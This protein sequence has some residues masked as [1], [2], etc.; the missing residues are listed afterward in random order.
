MNLSGCS[1]CF[2]SLVIFSVGEGY[3]NYCPYSCYAY[4]LCL[5]K[6]TVFGK[7]LC[8]CMYFVIVYH[9]LNLYKESEPLCTSKHGILTKSMFSILR[10]QIK[11]QLGWLSVAEVGLHFSYCSI[12]LPHLGLIFSDYF[13]LLLGSSCCFLLLIILWIHI[14]Y[15]VIVN[16]L[17]VKII[18]CNIYLILALFCKEIVGS[19][20]QDLKGRR[21]RKC[22][23]GMLFKIFLH[24]WN[25][26]MLQLKFKHKYIFFPI[27][28]L[29]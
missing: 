12:V 21:C 24:Y 8:W 10:N 25:I 26:I 4:N 14:S 19:C 6:R 3:W 2:I 15:N 29:T 9:L 28:T 23:N 13:G 11:I 17:R 18:K 5:R 22:I 20:L 27:T 7:I 1:F 16:F